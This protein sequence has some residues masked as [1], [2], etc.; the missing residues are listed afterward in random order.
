MKNTIIAMAVVTAF[1]AVACENQSDRT[2]ENNRKNEQQQQQDNQQ[3]MENPFKMSPEEFAKKA[4]ET[5]L[6]EVQLG[7]LATKKATDK[8]VK[9]F[10]QTAIKDHKDANNKLMPIAKNK[11]VQIPATLPENEMKD[12]Q[13]LKQKT[14]VEFSKEYIDKVVNMHEETVDLYK[15]A[16]ENLQDPELSNYASEMLPHLQH[17]LESAKNIQ[18]KLEQKPALVKK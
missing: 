15:K 11:N 2:A 17:H 6:K 3:S 5:N 12:I 10:A 1:F 8:E 14:G 7:E 18:K 16:S 4:Y 13:D 9:N